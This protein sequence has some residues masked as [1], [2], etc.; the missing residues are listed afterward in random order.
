VTAPD[1]FA[2]HEPVRRGT[3]LP[4]DWKPSLE[5]A[6]FAR[7]LG[8]D[9][10]GVADRF[11]DYWIA[12]A[13]AGGVK[14]DWLATWRNWCRQTAEHSFNKPKARVSQFNL[15]PSAPPETEWWPRLRT[16]KPGGFWS[17]FWG[18]RPGEPGC[19]VPKDILARWK[20]GGE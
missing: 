12:R 1:L 16:Y 10:D 8:L 7:D 2:R 6:K 13:G 11:R 19:F 4:S 18:P 9:V 3:R 17:P 15:P 20:A 5:A 14:L